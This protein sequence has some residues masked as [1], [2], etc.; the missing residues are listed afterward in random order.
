MGVGV[1]NG[2]WERWGPWVVGGMILG[3]NLWVMVV[4]LN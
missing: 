3:S 4:C 2:W 1:M